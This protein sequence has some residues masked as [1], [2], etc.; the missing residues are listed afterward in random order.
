MN[1]DENGKKLH[2]EEREE[3]GEGTTS[4]NKF[5]LLKK[6]QMS[7]ATRADTSGAQ[8]SDAQ[9]VKLHKQRSSSPNLRESSSAIKSPYDA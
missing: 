6:S 4:G 2:I 3:D 1:D 5:Y 8:K 7:V 9:G